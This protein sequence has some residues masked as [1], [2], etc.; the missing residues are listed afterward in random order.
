MRFSA[1]VDA[2]SMDDLYCMVL[3]HNVLNHNLVSSSLTLSTDGERLRS[4]QAAWPLSS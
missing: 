1:A 4:G 2:L 3:I